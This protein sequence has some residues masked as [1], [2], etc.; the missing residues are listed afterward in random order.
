MVGSEQPRLIS[1]NQEISS[2]QLSMDYG[3]K[4]LLTW[5]TDTLG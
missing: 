1:L 2:S 5:P 4:G 3:D